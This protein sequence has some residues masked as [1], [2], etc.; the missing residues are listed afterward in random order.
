ML[1]SGPGQYTMTSYYDRDIAMLAELGVVVG[2]LWR[3]FGL[4]PAD[5]GAAILYDHFTRMC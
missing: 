5:S 3:Q 2:Q 1:G 4:R